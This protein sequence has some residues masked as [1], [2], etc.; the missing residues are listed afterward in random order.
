MERA[1]QLEVDKED[2][3]RLVGMAY[4]GS[5]VDRS[6]NESWEE[7]ADPFSSARLFESIAEAAGAS[8]RLWPAVA[9]RPV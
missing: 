9:L 7:L 1:A 3:G 2:F 4:R 8:S 5:C 6:R